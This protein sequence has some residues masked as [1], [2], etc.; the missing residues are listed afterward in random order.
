MTSFLILLIVLGQRSTPAEIPYRLLASSLPNSADRLKEA[1]F[2]V[3]VDRPMGRSEVEQLVCNV[4][5]KEQPP[6]FEKLNIF[7]FIKL[8]QYVFGDESPDT[9]DHQLAWYAWNSQ[10][11][12][13]RGRLVMTRDT[14]GRRFDQLQSREFNKEKSCHAPQ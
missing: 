2:A 4:L 13:V 6:K 3:S 11:P 9:L 14:D 1:S 12:R 7:V 8:D 5:A 10:L